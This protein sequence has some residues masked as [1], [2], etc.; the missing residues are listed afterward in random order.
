MYVR[1]DV[2][3]PATA[4][5]TVFLILVK[6]TLGIDFLNNLQLYSVFL[7]CSRIDR[8]KHEFVFVPVAVL[9]SAAVTFRTYAGTLF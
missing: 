6:R 7:V 9:V 2:V 8:M 5:L 4:P 1:T 3:S